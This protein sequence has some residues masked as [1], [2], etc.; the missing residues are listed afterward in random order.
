M[1]PE[2]GAPDL[3]EVTFSPADESWSREW[4]HFAEAILAGDDRALAGDLASARYG[5][6]CIEEAYA[7]SESSEI[8]A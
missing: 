6:A 3:E 7:R 4:R 2:L 8:H 5:W 1:R